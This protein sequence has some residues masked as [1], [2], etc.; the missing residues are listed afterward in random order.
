MP[1]SKHC[2][3][4]I[5]LLA[6]VAPA[7]H[8]Q[9][10]QPESIRIKAG[11]PTDYVWQAAKNENGFLYFA[12]RRGL[13]KYDGYHFYKNKNITA[14]IASAAT[15]KNNTIYYSDVSKGL[16]IISDIADIPTVIS[17]ADYTD[18]D[19]NNDHYES[20]YVDKANR[21]WCT[22]FTQV[23]YYTANH[24]DSSKYIIDA[25]GKDI[26]KVSFIEL[27]NGN[28][29]IATLTGL[30][31]WDEKKHQFG[32]FQDTTISQLK[33]VSA[34]LLDV[35]N[36]LL[37]TN[38]GELIFYN[39]ANS[40]IT[41]R[42]KPLKSTQEE[43]TGLVYQDK[44]SILLF[45]ANALFRYK[46]DTGET[47]LLYKTD[48]AVINSVLY[49]A[50]TFII[51]IN[52][53]RG[54]VK[55][56]QKQDAIQLATLPA[57][58]IPAQNV[59]SIVQDSAGDIWTLAG[60][61]IL[62]YPMN[63]SWQSFQL[64]AEITAS[65]ITINHNIIF[66]CTNKGLYSFKENRFQKL[67]F[68]DNNDDVKKVATDKN[69][70]IWLL[71]SNSHIK[72]INYSNTNTTTPAINNDSSFWT[73]NKWN[74]I[75]CDGLGNIWL[76]G[77]VPP[78]YGIAR[79]DVKQQK[80]VEASSFPANSNHTVFVGDYF[81]RVNNG[82][83]KSLLFSGYGGFNIID[84]NGKVV[85][86]VGTKEYALASEIVEG[87]SQTNDGKVWFATA[88]GLNVWDS[89]SNK[90]SRISQTNGLPTDELING[91]CQLRNNQLAI[92]YEN[93]F[94]LIDQQ[95]ILASN[96]SNKLVLSAI[97]I[98]GNMRP[99]KENIFV[100]N[101]KENNI[102]LYF[103]SLSF[104]DKEKLI[105]RYKTED[106]DSWTYVN[107]EPEI[108]LSHIA[109]GTY[110][111][112]VEVGNTIGDWQ[113]EKLF[114]YLIVRPPFYQTYW[115]RFLVAAILFL[116][117]LLAY[118]YLLSQQKTREQI[119]RK[120]KEAQMQALRTQMNPHFIFNSLNSINSFILDKKTNEASEYLTTFS[121]LMRTTLELTRKD[122]VRLSQ[123]M[124]ALR[125]YLEIESAR[126]E[127]GFDYS[128]QV[129]KNVDGE[130]IC[131][132]PLIL[133]PF[134]ENAIWHGL[135]NKIANGSITVFVEMKNSTMLHVKIEDDGI[136][137]KKSAGLKKNFKEHKSYGMEIT[138]SRLQLHHP[139]NALV[140]DDIEN[141]GEGTGTVVHLYIHI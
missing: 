56:Q 129:D 103:S 49:D 46:T 9:E 67:A 124:E 52:S 120:L 133:Q 87:I 84:S 105:Y 98:N 62:R 81:N 130:G 33:I 85:S 111:I 137:R 74:D 27:A 64:P 116:L 79:Y 36:I 107:E 140:I 108:S 57:T 5:L 113:S 90:V 97:E 24:T 34:I 16:C 76:A 51:W 11:L 112:T 23:K 78:G 73:T 117:V 132:P 6:I 104:T 115:F 42:F 88:E 54:I 66:V 35:N 39:T 91:Y 100:L 136:G 2:F 134:V 95:K 44:K 71:L 22:D 31:T 123:E 128:I 47:T 21:I 77:W 55:L 40:N 106:E 102:K 65:N 14:N 131:I 126:L 13:C 139:E 89:H 28:M 18:A 110:N 75:I 30:F 58:A 53:N 45:A 94:I 63:K 127:Q 29:L 80:F 1:I 61:N 92:G 122:T 82:I 59:Q 135:R 118:R 69:A 141:E 7:L 86:S 17:P 68:P 83:N 121:R 96:F 119:Q 70:A 10:Y 32:S 109:P 101:S 26:K 15:D 4:V 8:A 43:I 20:I 125:L 12:T 19:P 3:W 99:V 25:S 72:I 37:A 48:G 41:R 114:V 93:G 138:L 38:D 60:N 50:T